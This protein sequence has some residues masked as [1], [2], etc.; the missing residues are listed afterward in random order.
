MI[1][2]KPITLALFPVLSASCAPLVP[3]IGAHAL[4]IVIPPAP[5]AWASLTDL[6]MSLSWRDPDG[7][8]RSLQAVPGSSCRIEVE[9][10][11][12][13]AIIVRPS[14]S[15]RELCPAGALYPEGIAAGQPEKDSGELQLDWRGGYAASIALALEGGGID[16]SCYDLYRLVDGAIARSGDPWIVSPVEAARRLADLDFRIDLY[17]EKARTSVALPGPGPWAP[18][19]PFASEAGAAASLPE[20]LWRFVGKASELFVSVDSEGRAAMVER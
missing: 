20:G 8:L 14:L 10:G 2:M 1:A 4:T 3:S 17:N 13:Q 5:A 19:S 6:R 7:R 15:G 16:P 11:F 18:E 12:P 9:R